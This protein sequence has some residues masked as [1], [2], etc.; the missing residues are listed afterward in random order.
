LKTPSGTSGASIIFKTL[1]KEGEDFLSLTSFTLVFWMKFYGIKYTTTTENNK[2]LSI[3][4]NTYLAYSKSTNNL[5]MLENSQKMFEDK[6]FINYFG[7]WI[8]ISIANYI[9][10]TNND[11]YPNMFTLSVNKKDIPFYVNDQGDKYAI[12][13]SGI[14]ITEFSLGYDLIALFS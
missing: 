7:R 9:S 5:I 2:I 4:A 6:D 14:K 3:D 1:N 13:D 11:V 8:P 10:N 12:P